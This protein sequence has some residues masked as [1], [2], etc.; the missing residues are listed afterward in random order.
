LLKCTLNFSVEVWKLFACSS[1][2]HFAQL[3]AKFAPA[4]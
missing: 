1:L 4:P 3:A 2:W